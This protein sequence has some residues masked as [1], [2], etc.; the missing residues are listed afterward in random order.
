MSG[1]KT[2]R[3]GNR[4]QSKR[5]GDHSITIEREIIGKSHIRNA[6]AGAAHS[7]FPRAQRRVRVAD[8]NVDRG[9][10]GLRAGD[11]RADGGQAVGTIDHTCPL[12]RIRA[13]AHLADLRSIRKKFD[14]G[15]CD[16]CVRCRGGDRDVGARGIRHSVGGPCN[17]DI[18]LDRIDPAPPR[19]PT[20]GSA[21]GPNG[22]SRV[23]LNRPKR[24]IVHRI[25]NRG[26]EIAPAIGAAGHCRVIRALTCLQDCVGTQGVWRVVAIPEG[27]IAAGVL[28]GREP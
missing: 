2:P 4:V 18:R 7:Q 20:S 22:R 17:R 24:K 1:I 27:K 25:H 14:F 13:G 21:Q 28:R 19:P 6:F 9:G 26:A 23:F 12:K 16:I 3:A 11:F 10:Y 8:R 5:A 15:Q